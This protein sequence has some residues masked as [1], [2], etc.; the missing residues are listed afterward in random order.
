MSHKFLAMFKREDKNLQKE[1][2]WFLSEYDENLSDGWIEDI[3]CN[4]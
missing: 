2:M 3:N 1:L 4:A